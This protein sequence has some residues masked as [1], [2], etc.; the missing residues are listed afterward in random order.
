MR[1]FSSLL[2]TA[3]FSLLGALAIAVE[4]ESPDQR[5]A[6]KD[7]ESL[8]ALTSTDDQGR[9]WKSA[10]HVGKILVLYSYP[11]DFTPGCTRQAETFREGL[12]KLEERGVDLVGISGD[13]VATHKLF[14]EAYGLKHTLLADPK[15]ELAQV[16]GVPVSRGDKV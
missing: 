4:P 11:G 5:P 15:G 13:E 12:A 10:E 3:V 6:V 16:L 14:K 1:M 8:P 2:L 7:G 9:A